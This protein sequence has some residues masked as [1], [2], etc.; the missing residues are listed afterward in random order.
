MQTDSIRT[1]VSSHADEYDIYGTIPL[2]QFDSFLSFLKDAME[3]ILSHIV[4]CVIM[5]IIC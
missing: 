4:L 5:V 1:E 2:T 3:V